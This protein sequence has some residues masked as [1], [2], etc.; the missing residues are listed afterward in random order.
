M[1]QSHTAGKFTWPLPSCSLSLKREGRKKILRDLCVKNGAVGAVQFH[2]PHRRFSIR[3]V[4]VRCWNPTEILSIHL[5]AE[6]VLGLGSYWKFCWW[7]WYNLAFWLFPAL[8]STGSWGVGGCW[9]LLA[10]QSY[11]CSTTPRYLHLW[12]QPQLLN[13]H[14][15]E[16]SQQEETQ[17]HC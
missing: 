15:C 8:V 1:F 9:L 7:W 13:F 12:Q 11:T 16:C 4:Q 14:H 2:G 10:L 3:K 6:W 17:S 5:L